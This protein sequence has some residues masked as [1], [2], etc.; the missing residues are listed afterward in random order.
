MQATRHHIII[1]GPAETERLVRSFCLLHRH[2]V[3]AG[4]CAAAKPYSHSQFFNT[5]WID[6]F[7]FEPTLPKFDIIYGPRVHPEE[8]GRYLKMAIIQYYET[9]TELATSN[10]GENRVRLILSLALCAKQLYCLLV[11]VHVMHLSFSWIIHAFRNQN[12]MNIDYNDGIELKQGNR[13]GTL[14]CLCGWMCVCVC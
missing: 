2:A 11:A 12:V 13:D 4:Y 5:L 6:R 9:P 1:K 3:R 7:A 14:Q 8:Y 10:M